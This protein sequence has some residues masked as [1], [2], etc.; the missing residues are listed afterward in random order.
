[1]YVRNVDIKVN[2]DSDGWSKVLD[3]EN[4]LS[5]VFFFLFARVTVI[6]IR[7]SHDVNVCVFTA[8]IELIVTDHFEFLF[9]TN[10]F[11]LLGSCT[12]WLSFLICATM[13]V[14]A[15]FVSA[16]IP[17]GHAIA[18]LL[19]S[20]SLTISTKPFRPRHELN[21]ETCSVSNTIPIGLLSYRLTK[22]AWK[23]CLLAV[24][25]FQVSIK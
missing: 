5:L 25:N 19:I 2:F 13:K 11:E 16:M 21:A 24:S 1:M 20:P 18:N 6:R 23:K 7:S 8:I 3:A 4:I 12:V 15:V 9:L 10:H 22:G 17:D 14:T